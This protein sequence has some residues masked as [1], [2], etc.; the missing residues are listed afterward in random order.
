MRVYVELFVKKLD[1]FAVDPKEKSREMGNLAGTKFNF[2]DWFHYLAFDIISDLSFGVPLYILQNEADLVEIRASPTS[3]ATYIKAIEALD[4]RSVVD[5]ALR[6]VPYL[7]PLA[8]R[9]F[10]TPIFR[11]AMRATKNLVGLAITRV[12]QRLDSP[13]P[14]ERYDLLA[15]VIKNQDRDANGNI[16][17]RHELVIAA[18]TQLAAGSDTTS[19]SL[20]AIVYYVSKTPYV[21]KRL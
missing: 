18:F 5:A 15:R 4:Q 13:P 17:D 10:P 12:A 8:H 14:T 1:R 21:M 3:P 11:N 7:K 2:L 16:K 19:N 9:I 6:H 20:G